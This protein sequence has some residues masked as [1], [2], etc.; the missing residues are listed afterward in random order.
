MTWIVPSDPYVRIFFAD[1]WLSWAGL[2][3]A[4]VRGLKLSLADR[5]PI[6]EGKVGRRGTMIG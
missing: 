1:G 3:C 6:D 5:G 2:A 4:P